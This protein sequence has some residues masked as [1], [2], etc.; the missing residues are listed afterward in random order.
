MEKFVDIAVDIE[1]LS[2]MP[3]A[4]IIQ[5]A[6]REFDIDGWGNNSD[7]SASFF[8][9]VDATSCAMYGLH[10]DQ[11]TVDFWSK[12]SYSLKSQFKFGYG[13]GIAQVLNEFAE[14][15][16]NL[17]KNRESDCLRVWMQGTD[18]DGVI[19]R[20]AFDVVSV[21]CDLPWEYNDLRDSRTYVLE[22]LRTFH[23]DVA[24]PYTCIPKL[25]GLVKHYAP[26][27][28]I[29]LIHCVQFCRYEAKHVKFS[30]LT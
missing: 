9:N 11:R 15:V 6:A 17:K 2:L 18:F 13:K 10:F 16:N 8:K 14:W 26:D 4:A 3:N 27:D 5:I 1:T 23:P 25:S 28:V 29:W 22:H 19:L 12:Q 7:D 30:E 20:N 21:D 24:D